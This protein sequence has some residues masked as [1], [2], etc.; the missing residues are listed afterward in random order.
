MQSTQVIPSWMVSKN[1]NV[2]EVACKHCGENGM[3][4]EFVSVL[5]EFRDYLGAPVVINSGYRC[6]LHPAELVKPP[7]VV[8]R[9]RL[10]LAVDI[11]SP[12]MS[13]EDLYSRVEEFGKFLGVGVSI[14][15]GFIH[16]DQRERKA[17]WKYDSNGKDI[18]WDGRWSSLKG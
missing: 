14:H 13:L 3:K 12:G 1:F 6:R 11:Q 18:P 16:C 4:P 17:R 2:S 5:Q 15:G 10:G 7:G 8:G 9:H